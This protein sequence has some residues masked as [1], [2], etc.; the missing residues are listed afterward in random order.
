MK[1]MIKKVATTAEQILIN[2][3]KW[4]MEKKIPVKPEEP[5]KKEHITV[6][7]ETSTRSVCRIDVPLSKGIFPIILK[8]YRGNASNS[9]QNEATLYGILKDTEVSE[10]IPVIYDIQVLPEEDETWIFM[11]C[12]N[13]M[14]EK[15]N[16]TPDDLYK[17]VSRVA[18]LHAATFEK[19]PIAKRLSKTIPGFQSNRRDRHLETMKRYLQ[20]AR[21]HSV[22]Q[23]LIEKH[24]PRLYELAELDLDFPDVMRSDRC[25]IH[26]DLHLGNIC[27]DRVENQKRSIQ[28]IDFSPTFSPCWLDI[29]KPVEFITDHHPEWSTEV[30]K[31][32]NQSIQIYTGEMKKKG[33]TFSEEP[34]RMYRFAYLTT[35][36]EKELRRHLKFI[37]YGEKRYIFP[38]ILEKISLFSKEVNMI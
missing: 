33:I 10:F 36:F 9:Y 38:S 27:Y 28:F 12:L 26:G 7:K 11:K 6:I 37:L 18:Q 17:I 21:G 1:G 32:R 4:A 3:D 19:Q 15:A 22:L 25:L 30:N 31:I 13:V 23:R 2:W 14:A 8:V 24:C 16:L 35:V 5:L 29:V 20:E 34:G